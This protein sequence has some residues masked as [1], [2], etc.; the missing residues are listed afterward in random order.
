MHVRLFPFFKPNVKSLTRM[1]PVNQPVIE[2]F[3][4]ETVQQ[5]MC[6]IRANAESS[7]RSL[8]REV[9]KTRGNVLTAI[10]YLD[11]G[12]PVCITLFSLPLS[13]HKHK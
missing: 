7:V 8:L 9:A 12:S 6:N 3:T 11:E 10:D 1:L 2:E 4:L 13:A 5:Y